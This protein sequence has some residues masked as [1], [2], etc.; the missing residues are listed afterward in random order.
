VKGSRLLVLGIGIG[1]FLAA[2]KAHGRQLRLERELA[3]YFEVVFSGRNPDFV[4]NLW[5]RERWAFWSIAATVAAITLTLRVLGPKRGW[6]L[7]FERAAREASISGILLLHAVVPMV[8]AFTA[9]GLSSFVRYLIANDPPAEA[10]AVWG[11]AGW[12]LLT[13]AMVAAA[14][15]LSRRQAR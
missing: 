6:A 14:S 12:W 5:R 10:A 11:S 15:V 2:A 13:L 3:G 1:T 8:V 7:P 4:E 9:T